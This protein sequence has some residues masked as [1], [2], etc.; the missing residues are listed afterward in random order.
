MYVWTSCSSGYGRSKGGERHSILLQKVEQSL[1]LWTIRMKLD[2]HRVAMIQSPTIMNGALA[3]DSY[4]QLLM[5][6]VGK[7]PLD[8]PSLP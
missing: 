7:E 5:K 2:V 3:E 4:R 6:R 1:S 8:L